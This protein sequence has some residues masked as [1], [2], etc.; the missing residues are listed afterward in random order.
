V[1]AALAAGKSLPNTLGN[2][3]DPAGPAGAGMHKVY[4]ADLYDAVGAGLG[5]SLDEFKRRLLEAHLAGQVQLLRDDIGNTLSAEN[6]AKSARS[7]VTHLG[8]TFHALNVAWRPPAEFAAEAPLS[9][10]PW[11]QFAFCPTGPGGGVDPSCPPGGGGTGKDDKG[12]RGPMTGR[13]PDGREVRF[14]P[15]PN[16]RRDETTVMV[17]AA[18]LDRAWSKDA[19]YYVPPGAPGIPGRREGVER[20]LARGEPVQASLLTLDPDGTAS[21]IDGRHRFAVLRDKGIDRVAVTVPR[22]QAARVREAL[23]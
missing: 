20:F 11:A 22:S 9:F 14:V 2:P 23:G 5:M 7:E 8:A 16:Q 12:A 18:K 17:D 10:T 15:H 6:A 1:D 21:F 4:L 19:G 3:Y 13:L